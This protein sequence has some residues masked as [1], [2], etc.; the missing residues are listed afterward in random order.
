ML[1]KIR[2]KMQKSLRFQRHN[3]KAL[4]FTF[5]ILFVYG[6][7]VLYGSFLSN[8]F[9]AVTT[10]NELFPNKE[11]QSNVEYQ[12][13]V[14]NVPTFR[15]VYSASYDHRKADNRS[16]QNFRAEMGETRFLS[17]DPSKSMF[18]KYLSEADY[19]LSEGTK[20]KE[21][22]EYVYPCL[23]SLDKNGNIHPLPGY[24]TFN[25]QAKFDPLQIKPANKRYHYPGFLLNA[26]GAGSGTHS[27]YDDFINSISQDMQLQAYYQKEEP[28]TQNLTLQK[29][30]AVHNIKNIKYISKL[31]DETNE[32]DYSYFLKQGIADFIRNSNDSPNIKTFNNLL[33]DKTSPEADSDY[34]QLAP[35][36][37]NIIPFQA[38]CSLLLNMLLALDGNIGGLSLSNT[39]FSALTQYCQ[40]FKLNSL[41]SNDFA[42]DF[43]LKYEIDTSSGLPIVTKVYGGAGNNKIIKGTAAIFK[44]GIIKQLPIFLVNKFKNNQLSL[45]INL[46]PFNPSQDSKYTYI[47][48]DMTTDQNNPQPR[49]VQLWGLN[50]GDDRIKLEDQKG[51][52]L[53]PLLIQQKPNDSD[54]I[55]VIVNR[56]FLSKY[57]LQ[58]GEQFNF[59]F[60]KKLNMLSS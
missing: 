48:G 60:Q 31:M 9:V 54:A 38:R 44:Q 47:N 15:N 58:Q 27:V 18:N 30:I 28:Q 10:S 43:P 42:L 35:D 13:Y 29:Q 56:T 8:I 45:N 2:Q 11:F 19:P 41:I 50:L 1:S 21:N 4:I 22:D 20:L 39:F 32:T 6:C 53:K 37:N 49:N 57:H 12:N 46:I 33:K 59:K 5:V 40:Y 24:N 34:L 51:Q 52:D 23:H 17:S 25:P 16:L 7:L 14:V 55:P 3:K 26:D 36:N